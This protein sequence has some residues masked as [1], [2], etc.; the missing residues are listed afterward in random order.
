[1]PSADNQGRDPVCCLLFAGG[2]IVLVFL[3]SLYRTR[4]MEAERRN[5]SLLLIRE[6]RFY[7]SAMNFMKKVLNVKK[8]QDRIKVAMELTSFM[9]DLGYEKDSDPGR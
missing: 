1:M 4:L 9:P 2:L 8:A 7:K 5:A 6:T 3:M